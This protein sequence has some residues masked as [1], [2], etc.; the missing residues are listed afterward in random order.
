[1]INSYRIEEPVEAELELV[2][3]KHNFVLLIMEVSF[4]VDNGRCNKLSIFASCSKEDFLN[5]IK[6][7]S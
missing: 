7:A 2:E 3:R 1:M 4:R 6:V 5:S